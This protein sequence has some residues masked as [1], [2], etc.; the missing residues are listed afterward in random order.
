[1]EEGIKGKDT[2]KK[3][4]KGLIKGFIVAVLAMAGLCILLGYN[5]AELTKDNKILDTQAISMKSKA[6]AATVEN[7]AL[8]QDFI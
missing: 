8:A 3:S 1:M 5:L 7:Q 4:R 6:N 2:E